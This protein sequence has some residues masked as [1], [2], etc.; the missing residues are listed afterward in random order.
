MKRNLCLRLPLVF[1][2]VSTCGSLTALGQNDNATAPVTRQ[3]EVAGNVVVH[4]DW[5]IA[6]GQFGLRKEQGI[7]GPRALA[8]DRQGHV[9]VADAVNRRLQRFDDSG[10]FAAAYQY[11]DV[12]SIRDIGV[13]RDGVVFV[14]DTRAVVG[15]LDANSRSLEWAER[16]DLQSTEAYRIRP[17]ANGR[18]YIEEK[19]VEDTRHL[20][21]KYDETLRYLATLPMRDLCVDPYGDMPYGIT[22]DSGSAQSR[23]IIVTGFNVSTMT[24]ETHSTQIET[25]QGQDLSRNPIRLVGVDGQFRIYLFVPGDQERGITPKVLQYSRYMQ[26][27]ASTALSMMLGTDVDIGDDIQR[28]VVD[29]GGALYVATANS[30][31]GFSI[32]K[33]PAL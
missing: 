25:T 9:Y 16:G 28:I 32:W 13:R 10:Q 19:G 6:P 31:D 26:L 5:G 4:G 33:V 22:D 24:P 21:R 14:L 2:V 12:G 20:V 30:R 7:F 29:A 23:E 18:I 8:V 17:A 27:Q 15:F 11:P 1:A 3:A